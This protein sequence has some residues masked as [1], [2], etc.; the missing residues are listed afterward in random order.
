[1]DE[2]RQVG[3]GH[4]RGGLVGEAKGHGLYPEVSD[5]QLEENVTWPEFL[6][7]MITL[8]AM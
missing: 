1:M 8:A 2:L 6:F 4:I 5:D 7:G 3:R